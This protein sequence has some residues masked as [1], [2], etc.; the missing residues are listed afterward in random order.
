MISVLILTKNEAEVLADALRSV[1]W[2]DDI[3]VF[4]SFS[5]DG[6]QAIARSL[7]AIVTERHFDGY[8]SQRNAA[9]AT[10]PFRHEWIFILDADERPSEAL[11]REMA[12]RAADA[13][14]SL[15]AFRV[16]RRDFL[17]GT[18]LKHAQ[19]TPTYLRLVRRGRARYVR[20]V[21]EHLEVDGEV[22]DLQGSLEHFPF[23]KGIVWWV[24]RHNRYSTMEAEL[25][26]AG[27]ATKD[28][29][30][31]EALVGRNPQSRRAAQ[32]AIFYKVPFRPLFKWVYMMFWRGALLDGPAGWTYAGL[33]TVYEYL[34]EVKRQEIVRGRP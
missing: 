8:A 33:Q 29:S 30:W 1:S 25:L 16:R 10:L 22:G 7:G 19:I 9:L 4:D 34:I 3:H 14:L 21:N 11:S 28:A 5:E 32:K 18:W 6:T 31:R 23:S 12:G 2:S 24:E 15:A 26:A 13:P 17:W 20:E 27:T